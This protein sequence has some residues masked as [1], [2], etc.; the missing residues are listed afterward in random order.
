MRN[1]GRIIG[2]RFENGA[3][4]TIGTISNTLKITMRLIGK[5]V[6]RVA[7]IIISKTEKGSLPKAGSTNGRNERKKIEKENLRSRRRNL[8]C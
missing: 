2:K 4:P 3:E 8:S 6:G 5:N 1:I 7:G